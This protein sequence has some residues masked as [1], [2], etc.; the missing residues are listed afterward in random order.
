MRAARSARA[1]RVDAL[2]LENALGQDLPAA[3]RTH[4]SCQRRDALVRTIHDNLVFRRVLS[5]VVAELHS[6]GIECLLLKGLAIEPLLRPGGDI[7]L[8]VNKADLLEA[9]GVLLR[10]PDYEYV[11]AFPDGSR[12]CYR[13]VTGRLARRIKYQAAWRHEFQLVNRQLGVLVELHISL[14]TTARSDPRAADPPSSWAVV[15]RIWK[16]RIYNREIACHT[17]SPEHSLLVACMHNSLKRSPA[18]NLLR[19]RNLVDITALAARG[20]RWD[21]FLHDCADLELSHH[22]YFSLLLARRLLGAAVPAAALRAL[23]LECTSLQRLL[24]RLHIRCVASLER[25]S[26]LYMALYNG[27]LP[28]SVP[29]MWAERLHWLFGLGLLLPTRDRMRRLLRVYG[30]SGAA[31]GVWLANPV[32]WLS[33]VIGRGIMASLPDEDG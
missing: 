16:A 8:L 14:F 13:Q 20:V 10:I 23:R 29:G 28:W 15:D 4:L 31:L 32:R 30:G 12:H 7:D 33:Q 11:E 26:R 1:H 9:I 18:K 24:A 17:P 6:A 2:F 27:L 21:S 22:A 19:L 25:S 3:A 5:Q